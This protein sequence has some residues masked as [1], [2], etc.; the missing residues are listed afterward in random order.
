MKTTS[1]MMGCD[2]NWTWTLLHI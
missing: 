1:E 2:W